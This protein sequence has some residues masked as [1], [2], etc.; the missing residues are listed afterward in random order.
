MSYLIAGIGG[1]LGAATRLYVYRMIATGSVSFPLATLLV[2][3]LGSAAIGVL[4]AIALER[5]SAEWRLFAVTGFLGAFT[6]FSAFSLDTLTLMQS[7]AWV[8]AAVN[9]L[10][11]VGLCLAAVTLGF[12]IARQLALN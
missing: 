6:T 1:F 12:Y 10:A 3:V 4:A 11:N 9:V 8:R 5:F 2:N 7:G